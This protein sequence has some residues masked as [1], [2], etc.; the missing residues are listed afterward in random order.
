MDRIVVVSQSMYFPWVGLLE[1]VRLADVFVHYDNVQFARGFFNR[2]QVKTS[3][4]RNWITVP[5]RDYHQGDLID[6]VLV[7]DREDW[8]SKHRKILQHAYQKAPFRDD[9]LA[10][11]DR[12]FNQDA[13]TLGGL[14]RYSIL[15]LVRYFNLPAPDFLNARAL[16]IGGSGSQRLCD[17]VNRL[18][19]TIYVTGH[20]AK[21][22]LDH[23]LFESSGIN[24]RYMN[25]E[26]TPYPQ[27]YG[28]FTPYVSGLDLVANCGPEGARAVRSGTIDWRDFRR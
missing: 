6:E 20:G 28:E 15:E 19:G 11:V 14:S 8:R 17:I 3:S 7:D 18:N 24:V 1:Q 27:L 23:Q 2:V 10:I 22:Y 4:G 21:N 16:N 12:V 9:M 25:Y 26:L 13:P 5:L